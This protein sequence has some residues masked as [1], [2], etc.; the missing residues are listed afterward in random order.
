VK[1]RLKDI[2]PTVAADAYVAPT[3]VLIGRVAVAAGASVW[4]NAVLRGDNEPVVVGPDSNVQDNSVLHTDP[5]QPLT[6][7]RAV[8]VGHGVILHGCTIDDESLIGMGA[9]VLNGARIGRHCLIGAGA[10]VTEGK[11]IPDGSLVIGSPARV[12]RPL[13]EG[14]LAMIRKVTQV[15]VA[16]GRRYREELAPDD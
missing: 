4:W 7:G 16:R 3:A 2:R 14:E 9:I 15:Y 11:D 8:T 1:Y 10:L 13:K 5:G 6:I 12:A